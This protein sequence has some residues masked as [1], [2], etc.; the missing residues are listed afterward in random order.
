MNIKIHLVIAHEPC[1]SLFEKMRSTE[2]EVG[3]IS[4]F[5]GF[6][7]SDERE[8]AIDENVRACSSKPSSPTVSD[9]NVVIRGREECVRRELEKVAESDG[10]AEE[11]SEGD[12]FVDT[13]G[14][15]KRENGG[16]PE[17]FTFVGF[18]QVVDLLLETLLEG[19][20]DARYLP[21]C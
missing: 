20:V 1:Q 11:A 7:S 8:L 3:V 4:L 12:S 19:V 21:L 18:L 2:E 16:E 10:R 5:V 9:S 6:V 17:G 13:L 14:S 15:L